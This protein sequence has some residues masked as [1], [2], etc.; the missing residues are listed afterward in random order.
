MIKQKSSLWKNENF[1]AAKFLCYYKF[2]FGGNKNN[3]QLLL[4]VSFF[5]IRTFLNSFNTFLLYN[6]LLSILLWK[7]L[8]LFSI[9][10]K[11]MENRYF[12]YLFFCGL[13]FKDFFVIFFL[14]FSLLWW[15]D[16]TFRGLLWYS[17]KIQGTIY[18]ESC[19]AKVFS[20]TEIFST[21]ICL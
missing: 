2:I 6:F 20:R 19:L 13:F 15:L 11:F 8:W 12:V 21:K 1:L 7:I 14:W 9:Q 4:N 16:W 5:D 10:G 17:G 3:S 18:N